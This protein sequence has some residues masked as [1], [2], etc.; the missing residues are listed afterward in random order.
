M[1]WGRDLEWTRLALS[2]D[3]SL[4]S[5]LEGPS[6]LDVRRDLQNIDLREQLWTSTPR[7][8]TTVASAVA[9]IATRGITVFDE[10]R[11]LQTIRR[12]RLGCYFRA[13]GGG[14]VWRIEF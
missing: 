1:R 11:D 12:H 2:D 4:D 13:R 9:S 10:T 6:A 8:V 5:T 3:L 14:L 7:A